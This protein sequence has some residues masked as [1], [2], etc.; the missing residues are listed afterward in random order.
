MSAIENQT[1]R[2]LAAAQCGKARPFRRPEFLNFLARLC[3]ATRRRQSLQI[4]FGGLTVR[5]SLTTLCCGQ[6]ATAKA[7][8]SNLSGKRCKSALTLILILLILFPAGL[9]AQRRSSKNP[10]SRNGAHSTTS[11]D[12]FTASDRRLV[13]RA[14][15]ATCAERIRDPQGSMP[16][17]EMQ[18]RPS[19]PVNNADAVEGA[20]RAD[21]LLP[22]TRKLVAEAIIRLAK[23]YDLYDGAVASR[24]I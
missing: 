7:A 14:I 23:E 13:E 16:I 17:D 11:R 5:R 10:S 8:T 22:A 19:L 1:A 24:K 12:T 3:L 4:S 9:F 15:G 21:R 20:R 6:A 18:S 2:G